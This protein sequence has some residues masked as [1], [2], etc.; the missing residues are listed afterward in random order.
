ME[1]LHKQRELLVIWVSF[2]MLLGY[3]PIIIHPNMMLTV[4]LAQMKIQLGAL[5]ANTARALQMITAAKERDS[6]LILF[7]ELWTSGY[8]LTNARQHAH[9]NRAVLDRLAAEAAQKDMFIGGSYLLEREGDVFN[10]F[11]LIAPDGSRWGYEKIHLFRLM[12]EH[13]WLTPGNQMVTAPIGPHPAGI[14]ICYDLRFPE[15]F[16][17]YA[18]GGAQWVLLSAEWP[19]K[20][21]THW[22]VLLRARAIENQLFVLAVNNVGETGA[23]TFG[24]CSALISPWGEV[25][26]EGSADQEELLVASIVLDE[27]DQVRAHIPILSDRRPDLY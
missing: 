27:V 12:D 2:F 15:L 25:L 7:P 9:T 13:L 23:E 5:E 16:R 26:V 22:Q 20:R 18:A 19:S 8:D 17:H 10:T 4:S 21:T 11:V 6:R 24:G 14:A 3:L 1:L